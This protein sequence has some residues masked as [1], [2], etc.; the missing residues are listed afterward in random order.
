MFNL[1]VP[2]RPL[3]ILC[4]LL[5]SAWDVQAEDHPVPDEFVYCTVC[6]GTL[7]SGNV[8]TGAPRLLGLSNW[9]IAA[10]LESFSNGFR[11]GHREDLAGI[12]MRPMAEMLSPESQNEVS[13]LISK[14]VNPGSATLNAFTSPIEQIEKGRQ[15]YRSCSVCHGTDGT[16]NRR[17][18]APNLTV[19]SDWYLI[20][21]LVNY[22][23][24]I[25]GTA[26]G[27]ERGL[28]MSAAVA[29]LNTEQDIV[30]VVAYIRSILSQPD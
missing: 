16:G 24:K 25:R 11:G 21:Q 9:Y 15:H 14:L 13:Q 12:E 20:Q 8:A 23:Q 18:G 1:L 6:H 17:L 27:D 10:Q 26:P 4:L 3:V 2:L 29:T 30:D 7:F 28:Q 5:I 19:Q 22:R